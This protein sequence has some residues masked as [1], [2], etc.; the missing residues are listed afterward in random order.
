MQSPNDAPDPGMDSTASDPL[1]EGDFSNIISFRDRVG[2]LVVA[3]QFNPKAWI[4][5]DA[6]VD[7]DRMA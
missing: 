2:R 3:D 7:V 4:L 5:S 6:T 1:P